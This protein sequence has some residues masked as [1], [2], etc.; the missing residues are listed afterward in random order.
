MRWRLFRRRLSISSPRMTVRSHLPWPL[1]WAAVA[2]A[3]GFSGALA[4]WAF[5]FGKGIAGLDHES[6]NAAQ[7]LGQLRE[8]MDDLKRDRDQA[9]SIANTADSLLKAERATQQRLAEQVK[10][11]EMENQAL[12]DD[13]G[14]F[15]RLLPASGE[16]MTVRGL[17]AS[18]PAAGQ[19]RFQLLVMQ[20]GGRTQPEFRG[21]YEVLLSGTQDGKAWAPPTPALTKPLQ[22]RQYQRIDGLTEIP[23]NVVVRQ[24]QVRVLDEQ[25]RLHATQSLKL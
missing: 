4:L 14:F 19:L 9:Q 20:Q 18:V 6:R 12:K 2:V 21:R 13:L 11:L 8:Q 24:V 3:L 5:E 1:R 16:G 15:E 25:G 22:M 23:V 17:Q 10:A 7:V